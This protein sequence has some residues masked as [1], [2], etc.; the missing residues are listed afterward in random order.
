MKGVGAQLSQWLG[1][2]LKVADELAGGGCRSSLLDRK[3]SFPWL[4]RCILV[5]NVG[6]AVTE[7]HGSEK[8]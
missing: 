4:N 8:R 5:L 3:W 1:R 6:N 7:K 2:G